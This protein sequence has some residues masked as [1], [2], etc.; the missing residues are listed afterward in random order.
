[1]RGKP[2]SVVIQ[3]KY[4]IGTNRIFMEQLC[5]KM[6]YIPTGKFFEIEINQT[7]QNKHKTSIV[8]A[9]DYIELGYVLERDSKYPP[10]NKIKL[11]VFPSC[12]EKKNNQKMVLKKLLDRI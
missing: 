7:N 11:K 10:K 4:H 1:M 6:Q 9:R 5:C 2:A 12:P 3:G 8:T